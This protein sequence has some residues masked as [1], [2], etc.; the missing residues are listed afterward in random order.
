[1]CSLPCPASAT[2][3]QA[4]GADSGSRGFH[5]LPRNGRKGM[6]WVSRGD[7]PMS[8]TS[9]EREPIDRLAEEFLARFRRGEQPAV[10]EYADRYPELAGEIREL[11]PALVAM[12]HAAP[13]SADRSARRP[14]PA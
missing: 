5:S 10:A 1:M 4:D 6:K 9:S 8:N 3:P 14:T 12:E 13:G 11:Y 2:S 7:R